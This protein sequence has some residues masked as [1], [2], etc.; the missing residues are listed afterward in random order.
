MVQVG[1]EGAFLKKNTSGKGG[2][3]GEKKGGIGDI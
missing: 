2:I 1:Q 3:T